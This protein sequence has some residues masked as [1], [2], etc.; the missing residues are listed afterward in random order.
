M[1]QLELWAGPECTVNRVGDTFG[2]QF[3]RCGHAERIEDLDLF[4]GLGIKAIRYP[5]LW[6][7]IAPESPERCD[8]SWIDP[9]LNR[10]RELG[11]GV[12]AGL[13]HHG[14]GPAYTDLLDDE[15]FA[16][17]LAE[18]ARRVAERYPWIDR[19]TPVNEPLTTARFS[20]LYGHWYPH[21]R[22][23]GAF[24]RALLNQID[25]VR[26]SMAA[27]RAVNPA[28]KL[29]QTDD[30]GR[31]FATAEVRGQAAFDNVRRWA[32]WDLLC[33]RVTPQHPLWAHIA[34]FGL[35]AR[36]EAIAAAPCPP[37]VIGVNHYLTSD[38][39]LDHRLHRYPPHVHGGNGRQHYADVE[40][41]RVL[42]PAPPGLEGAVR[43]AWERYR[44]PVAVTEVHN[45]CTREEQMRW[46]AEA[47]DTAGR[48]RDDGV[49]IQAITIWSL[50]G[51]CGWNTL[52]TGPGIYEPGVF[53][54]SG[55]KPR[56]TALAAL[57]RG[58]PEGAP[59]PPAAQDA[60][61]WRRSTRLLHPT[62]HRPAALDAHRGGEDAPPRS[63]PLLILGATGTL[64]RAF[65]RACV[66][67]H[68]ACVVTSRREIDLRDAD[69]IARALDRHQPWA[70]INA[71]GW[72]RVDDAEG[73]PQA[74]H[75]A[76]ADGAI[77]LAAAAATRGI[78]TLNFSSDLVFDGRAAA[79][80]VE[81][82]PTSPLGVYGQSK[83]AMEQGVA[84]LSGQHLVA[85]TAAFFSPFDSYNFAVATA[86]A[87]AQ[88][89]RFRAARDLV[90]SPTYVP[91]LVDTALDLLIDGE[92]GLWHLTNGTAVSWAEFA[93]LIADQLG[94][95]ASLVESVPAAELGFRAPRPDF[96]PLATTRGS[97]LPP[98]ETAL[99]EFAA[100]YS[101][102]ALEENAQA[103]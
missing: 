81:T 15:G 71:A 75:E 37:D 39:F 83:V 29:I 85:R 70:V 50:L 36:L 89:E 80:Y 12:I 74:C 34:Q 44:I 23:E 31:T 52:L 82:D 35:A 90:V 102:T 65:A 103:A 54:V 4:A 47:W 56:A 59:R 43:E 7:R 91:H 16:R 69:S 27:I 30:L 1:G 45:G 55:G 78:A 66:H 93:G 92:S 61:W 38:R 57:M 9:R 42:E 87:L 32:G 97:A 18:H 2:D 98:L 84:S 73:Q 76:N 3:E 86:S 26:L 88:G 68:L 48:L 24:W 101:R 28:A 53:D 62:V 10:L 20:A 60:G 51:S 64:G 19:Y 22:D 79:P 77:R 6:E 17:G 95:R 63:A 49:D 5:V 33:G 11:I 58:L 21:A 100:H 13:L 41:V 67:R 72:V 8:W 25:G 40:A 94:L 96:V 46:M 14:S 99:A